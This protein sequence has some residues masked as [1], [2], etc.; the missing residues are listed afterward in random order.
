MKR[1][2]PK[3]VLF[4]NSWWH[5]DIV[6][7]TVKHAAEHGW[8][9]DLQTCMSGILPKRW[10]GDGVITLLGG[11]L[12]E[13]KRFL[14]QTRCPAVSLNA[15]Y[16]EIKLPRVSQDDDLAGRMAAEHFLERGFS[17]FAFYSHGTSPQATQRRHTEFEKTLGKAGYSVHPLL[18]AREKG[19]QDHTWLE[20]QRW[21]RRRLRKLAKPLA[22]FALNDEAAA[23][24]IE[25]SLSLS[26]SVPDE[27]A[28][29]GMLDMAVFRHSTTV[30]LSSIAVDF[31]AITRTGCDLLARMMDGED[32]P[33][34][35]IWFPPL[36]V[37]TRKSTDTI[38]ARDPVVA[39]AIRFMRDQHAEPIGI[40]EISQA[41]SVGKTSLYEHFDAD[42]EATPGSVL[43][44]IRLDR[45][46]RM[47]RE[48]DDKIHVVAESC[49]FVNRINLH[50]QF[51]RHLST[52][53]AAYR[54]DQS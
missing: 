8:H 52:S 32:V 23:E 11:D 43:A 36:G 6:N 39:K 4:A 35:P 44:R 37:I 24:V 29:L 3:R 30:P 9:L 33:T 42:I 46:K 48:T 25:A 15:N 13:L 17:S 26:L 34:E 14:K 50:R 41:A 40:P 12:D 18:W 22:V 27:V 28:V 47:L 16:P 5:A 38:A 51:K 49:G 1:K 45:A 31:D 7:G 21:L 10:S 2:T 20:R 53:P 54:R 19:R